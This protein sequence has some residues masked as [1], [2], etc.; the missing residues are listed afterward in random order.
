MILGY[1]LYARATAALGEHPGFR[2]WGLTP[3]FIQ[4]LLVCTLYPWLFERSAAWR[5]ATAGDAIESS[6]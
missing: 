1:V 3:C 4:F 2:F 5:R 6:T